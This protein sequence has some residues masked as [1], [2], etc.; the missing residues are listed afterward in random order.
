MHTL[1]PR[2]PA[3]IESFLLAQGQRRRATDLLEHVETA[4]ETPFCGNDRPR[5]N[6][7][8]AVLDVV[9]DR[10]PYVRHRVT[11]R[12]GYS[13]RLHVE[14]ESFVPQ[15]HQTPARIEM[16]PVSKCARRLYRLGLDPAGLHDRVRL[17]QIED[18]FDYRADFQL[19][20]AAFNPPPA[21]AVP[22]GLPIDFVGE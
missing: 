19:G 18:W 7:P 22:H 3:G 13:T 12:R 15:D 16:G 1:D 21:K 11:L 6:A 2:N 14:I 5:P 17:P 8:L 20:L 10:L 4:P 9:G